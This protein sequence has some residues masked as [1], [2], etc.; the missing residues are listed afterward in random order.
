M[1]EGVRGVASRAR[2]GTVLSVNRC[3]AT[4]FPQPPERI[5]FQGL[6]IRSFKGRVQW[7]RPCSFT[8][9]GPGQAA[10]APAVRVGNRAAGDLSAWRER[11]LIRRA[12]QRAVAK[13]GRGGRFVARLSATERDLAIRFTPDGESSLH[14]EQFD[15]PDRNG[16][17]GQLLALFGSFDN[18]FSNGPASST[19]PGKADWPESIWPSQACRCRREYPGSSGIRSPR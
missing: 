3:G 6:R 2:P 19:R 5:R 16:L 15:F 4:R 14:A 11:S 1:F 8:D 10:E 13:R 7:T 18:P 9:E 12:G 17:T